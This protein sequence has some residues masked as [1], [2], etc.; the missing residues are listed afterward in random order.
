MPMWTVHALDDLRAQLAYIAQ[1]NPE[2][3]RRTAIKIKVSCAGL[4]QFPRVG[5]EGAVQDTRELVIPGTA[6]VCVYRLAKGRVEILRLLHTRMMWP[7]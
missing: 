1:D 3:A 7:E 4:D 5:R 6:F 2:A